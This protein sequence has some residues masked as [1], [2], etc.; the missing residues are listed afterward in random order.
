[1]SKSWKAAN[2]VFKEWLGGQEDRDQEYDVS[3]KTKSLKKS[4]SLQTEIIEYDVHGG[5]D[6]IVGWVSGSY[7][8]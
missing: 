5:E 7:G 6:Q 2:E 3:G 8:G 1:M 4:L